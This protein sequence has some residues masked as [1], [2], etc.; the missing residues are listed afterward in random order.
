MRAAIVDLQIGRGTS[1]ISSCVALTRVAGREEMLIDRP[2]DRELYTQ[3]APE[4]PELLLKTLRREPVEWAAIEANR[5]L[6]VCAVAAALY[7]SRT[8]LC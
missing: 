6:L 5:T 4:G 8:S 2:F 3:G 1:A 7:T